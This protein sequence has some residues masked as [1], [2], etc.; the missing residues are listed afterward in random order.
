MPCSWDSSCGGLVAGE[1]NPGA[2]SVGGAWWTWVGLLSCMLVCFGVDGFVGLWVCG[3][4]GDSEY[5][6][7]WCI[8]M[9]YV[10]LWCIM[11]R[12]V[13]LWCIMEDYGGLWFIMVYYGA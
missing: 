9:R 7:S 8:M 5:G 1:Q 12:Y 2:L 3:F 10:V 6:A 11:M 13:V 4:V